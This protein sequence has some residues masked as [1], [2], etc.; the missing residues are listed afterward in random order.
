M[1]VVLRVRGYRFWFYQVDLD[2]PPHVHI[3]KDGKEAKFW[4]SPI[5]LARAGRFRDYELNEIRRIL[6][7]HQDDILRAWQKEQQKR[8]NR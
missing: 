5:A 8:G 2:E 4:V 7:I 3:G 1:P 6:V